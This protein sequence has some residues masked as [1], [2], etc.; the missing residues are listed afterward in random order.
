[1]II[2]IVSYNVSNTPISPYITPENLLDI[3][4]SIDGSFIESFGFQYHYPFLLSDEIKKCILFAIETG[5][6]P[7]IIS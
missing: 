5:I 3:P 6:F 2:D 1:M 7:A 4:L